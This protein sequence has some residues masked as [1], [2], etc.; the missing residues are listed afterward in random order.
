LRRSIGKNGVLKRGAREG[1]SPTDLKMPRPA[2]C[3]RRSNVAVQSPAVPMLFHVEQPREVN[4]EGRS[5]TDPNCLSPRIVIIGLTGRCRAP[6]S[7]CCFTWNIRAKPIGRVGLRPTLKCPDPRIV[8]VGRTGRCGAPPS[9]Y[10]FHVEQPRE[11]NREGR[12]PT[13]PNC[14]ARELLSSV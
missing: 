3:H 7:R 9:R 5:P 11:V 6:P 14:L 10:L 12:S 1:R 8:I 13:D 4:R 2:N